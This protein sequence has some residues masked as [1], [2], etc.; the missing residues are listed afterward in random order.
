MKKLFLISML[1]C[2]LTSCSV[3]N[4]YKT[5]FETNGKTYKVVLLPWKA[6]PMDFDFK[7]RWT[8]TQAL[9]DACKQS[10]AF[11][12]NWSSYPVN[13]KNINLLENIDFA[14]LWVRKKYGRYEPDVKKVLK[15]TSDLNADLALLYYVSADNVGSRG[16][17]SFGSRGDAVRLFAVD[18]KSGE[19]VVEFIQTDFLRKRAYANIKQVTLRA[20]NK[21]L[22]QKK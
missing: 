10:G 21:W 4:H 6:T 2:L 16:P 19:M 9:S 5:P 14:G 18:G 11:D 12:L 15:I 7:Y 1:L 8:M 20:F 17:D 3:A 13:A 22:S